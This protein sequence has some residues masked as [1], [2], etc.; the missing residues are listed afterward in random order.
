MAKYMTRQRKALLPYLRSHPDELLSAQ[1][2][3]EALG[4]ESVSLS[5][6]YRNLAD[7]EAEGKVRRHHRSGDREIMFQYLDTDTCRNCLHMSCTQCGRT[8]HMDDGEARQLLDAVARLDGFAIDKAETV[9]YGTCEEC[10]RN[11]TADSK[12]G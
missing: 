9:L 11:Q 8:F 5:A 10:G 6:V 2:I 12:D 3:A 1:E 7:L 4:V